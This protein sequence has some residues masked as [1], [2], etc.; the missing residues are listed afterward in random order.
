ML[1]VSLQ[2]RLTPRL[3]KIS[4]GPFFFGCSLAVFDI[5]RFQTS[6]A[7]ISFSLRTPFFLILFRTPAW[8]PTA[9]NSQGFSHAH[10]SYK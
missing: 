10:H 8:M 5:F 3:Y 9:F 6:H 2:L 4:V 7:I 1:S